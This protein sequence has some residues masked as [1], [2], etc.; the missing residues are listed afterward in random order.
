MSPW[1]IAFTVGGEKR[2][3]GPLQRA[4]TCKEEGRR[5]SHQREDWRT[6]DK[7]HLQPLPDC[8][9]TACFPKLLRGSTPESEGLSAVWTDWLA[10]K[11]WQSRFPLWFLFSHLEHKR[12]GLHEPSSAFQLWQSVW[13]AQ[14]F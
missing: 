7:L 11:P 13:L 3:G 10:L 8:P 1:V 6:T 14:P 12:V 5:G 9:N 4:L 2:R